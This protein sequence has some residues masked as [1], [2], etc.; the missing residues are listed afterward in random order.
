LP[1]FFKALLA[2]A[3]LGTRSY[4]YVGWH[5]GYFHGELFGDDVPDRAQDVDLHTALQHPT[6]PL[7]A[8]FA[9]DEHPEAG[10]VYYI[11]TARHGDFL[12]G[13]VDGTA[14][15]P[16]DDV[17]EEDKDDAVHNDR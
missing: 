8:I 2:E 12:A 3:A 10:L 11:P 1:T 15:V 9:S 4:R 14:A 16:W 7:Q 6:A 5:V 13:F 17:R